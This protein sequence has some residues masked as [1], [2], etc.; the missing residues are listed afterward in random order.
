[1]INLENRIA[2]VTG[3]G[4]GIGK[5]CALAL[6]GAGADI[7][8]NDRPGSPDLAAAAE[9]IR[10]LGRNCWP[11]ESDAHSREGCEQLLAKAIEAAGKIEILVSNPA[12]NRRGDFINY[13]PEWWDR[14]IQF[15]RPLRDR[16]GE[17]LN[18]PCCG[19]EKRF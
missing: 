5:G 8:L 13:D 9:E 15:A 11:I 12:I 14:T 3:G 17:S 6:A 16:K 4:R 19:V 18:R 7:V 2:L 10:Q 1:M